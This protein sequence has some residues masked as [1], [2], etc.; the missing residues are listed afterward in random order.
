MGND[1]IQ[2]DGSITLPAGTSVEDF[3]GAG[4]DGDDYVEGGGGNDLVFGDLGQDDLIGGSSSLYIAPDSSR[5]DGVDTIYGGAGT[6]IG[7]DD[8]GQ[9]GAAAHAR[10]ADVIAGDNASIYRLVAGGQFLAFA[11][12]TYGSLKLIPRAVVLLDYSPTGDAGYLSTNPASP[13]ATTAVAGTGANIGGGDFLHGEGGDDTIHG[14]GGR[15]TIFGDGQ[16]DSL[17]GEAGS[18]WLS[19]GAGD[20]GILGDDGLLRVSRNGVAEPLYGIAASTQTV[21]TVNGDKQAMTVNFTGELH[22]TADLEP[23]FLGANDIAYGGLGNDFLH[24]GV[25]DDALS[26]AEALAFYYDAGG[27]P[28]GVLA[29]LAAYYA[30]GNPLGYDP[31]TTKFRYFD[32]N[33]PWRKI[34]VAPGIEF[35][36]NFTAGT[37]PA[38]RDDGR[39]ALFGDSGND[40]LVGGT[41]EDHLYGGYGDDLLQADDD[42]DSTAG[43]AD[44]RANNVPDPRT[45][46]PTFADLAFGGAG[47]DVL[48]GNTAPDRLY[49][50]SGE[51]NSYF[52]PFSPFGEGTVTRTASPSNMQFLYD[53][54][55][56]DG[57]D[58]TRGGTASRNSE[59]FGEIGL[60]TTGDADYG[61]QQ[62][63]PRDPQPG[64][65]SNKGDGNS[66]GFTIAPPPPATITASAPATIS[67]TSA[68]TDLAL[69]AVLPPGKN[70]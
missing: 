50:W 51:F 15:D 69:A 56:A 49:D 18:D 44:P 67:S 32:A 46:A 3:A 20:D 9:T 53:A 30:D 5:P 60:V 63:G 36:L 52:V 22:Y 57:A 14:Q 42:L 19:G 41:N 59:P 8:A 62:G 17:Y 13:A 34:E 7:L 4:A 37:R 58:P 25:G 45:T 29:V 48:I 1:W 65:Y 23:F 38:V 43:T 47:R 27:N 12:D 61:A 54:S 16:D 35:L 33:D 31:V 6:R 26:G 40:W 11:Y 68:S 55:K 24:G 10:D 21:L 28:L 70:N 66:L 39:D 2:G 64:H